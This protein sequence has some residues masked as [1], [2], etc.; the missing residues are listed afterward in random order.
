M[1]TAG[2]GDS[3]RHHLPVPKPRRGN[4]GRGVADLG[5]WVAAGLPLDLVPS[6]ARG[7]TSFSAT[8][9]STE[10]VGSTMKSMKPAA[11]KGHGGH[12][13]GTRW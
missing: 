8:S 13:E 4:R 9:V 10:K 6:S 3:H 1:G 2:D 5:G 7:S 11:G 12:G